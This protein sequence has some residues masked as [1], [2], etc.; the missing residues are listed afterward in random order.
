M[1]D[2]STLKRT[3]NS[4]SR[5]KLVAV[6]RYED[7]NVAQYASSIG[8]HEEVHDMV[9]FVD[10]MGIEELNVFAYKCA[11]L[12]GGLGVEKRLLKFYG[13]E[14]LREEERNI[15]QELRQ[16]N[17][18]L[19]SARQKVA[20]CDSDVALDL[21][22]ANTIRQ[23]TVHIEEESEVLDLF[24]VRQRKTTASGNRSVDQKS[25]P[26]DCDSP[27]SKSRT[28]RANG[29]FECLWFLPRRIYFGIEGRNKISE[30]KK[31]YGLSP[32]NSLILGKAFVTDFGRPSYV[33]V[34]FTTRYAAVIA[35]QCLADG[36]S[37]NFWMEVDQIPIYPLADATPYNIRL[38]MLSFCFVSHKL[39]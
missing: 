17:Q 20:L 22:A 9:D 2:G 18:E 38:V 4:T 8:L 28:N 37:R 19:L 11:M 29:F 25:S 27:S 24:G 10:G 13:V 31:Y 12:A 16:A 33:V 23:P 3:P 32:D 5:D 34:T 1:M 36:A 30:T 21:D 26:A 14:T 7:F 15:V 35:R 39:F 6:F